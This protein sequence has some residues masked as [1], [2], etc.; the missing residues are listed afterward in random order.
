MFEARANPP[1]TQPICVA[2]Q[3]AEILQRVLPELF[4]VSS[5]GEVTLVGY[6]IP[7]ESVGLGWRSAATLAGDLRLQHSTVMLGR[8][9]SRQVV[10]GAAGPLANR[11]IPHC[12]RRIAQL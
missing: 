2:G 6:R 8:A 12:V 3:A 10:R 9:S 4:F 11:A 5:S 1:G 7:L